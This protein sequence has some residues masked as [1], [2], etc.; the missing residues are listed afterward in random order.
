MKQTVRVRAGPKKAIL[1]KRRSPALTEAAENY[2]KTILELQSFGA[3]HCVDVAEARGVTKA[4]VIVAVQ[5]LRSQGYLRT[6]IPTLE[7]TD[8]GRQLAQR[9]R[10]RSRF[11]TR[12]LQT[13]GVDPSTA[14]ADAC[15]MEHVLSDQSFAA[16]KSCLEKRLIQEKTGGTVNPA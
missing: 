10:E 7:L 1:A 12:L 6:D 2:L 14:D 9:M 3:V 4:S 13:A 16:L 5:R 15:R 8:A 11:F